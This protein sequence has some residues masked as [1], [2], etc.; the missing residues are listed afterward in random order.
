MRRLWILQ[1]SALTRILLSQF[2]KRAIDWKSLENAV[3]EDSY[4]LLCSLVAIDAVGC[5]EREREHGGERGGERGREREH[6]RECERE[7][8]RAGERGDE[9]E[10]ERERSGECGDEC[11]HERERGR[12]TF[13]NFK[14]LSG[15]QVLELVKALQCVIR[16]GSRMKSFA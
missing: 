8:E 5:C 10:H 1:E 4:S 16:A 14:D 2:R 12:D 13:R 7:R 9:C 3:M 15:M 11:E 6:G